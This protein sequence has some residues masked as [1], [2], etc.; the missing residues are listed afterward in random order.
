MPVVGASIAVLRNGAPELRHREHHGVGHS[1]TEV[2]GQRCDAAREIFEPARQLSLRRSLI[3]V[4]VPAPDVRER[5]FDADVGF[6]ELSD[7]SQ[8]LTVWAARILCAVL[9]LIF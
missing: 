7:L 8:R 6:D 5:D 4:R 3:D 2:R 9:W 1:I